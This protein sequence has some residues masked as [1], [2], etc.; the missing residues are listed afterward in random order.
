MTKRVNGTPDRFVN[1]IDTWSNGGSGSGTGLTDTELR[2]TPVTVD[3]DGLPS[4]AFSQVAVT[5]GEVAVPAANLA[6]R[7]TI[8]I[9]A[10]A[11]NGA[12]IYIGETGVTA[13]TGYEL[14]AGDSIEIDADATV[15]L[16]AVSL[17]GTQRCSVC[18]VA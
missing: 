11:A 3:F 17:S 8:S 2:L 14:S 1:E 6:S 4:A 13:S 5:V 7:K 15:V 10:L 16:F 12:A 18:E 9:K